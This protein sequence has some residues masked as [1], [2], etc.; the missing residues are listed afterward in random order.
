MCKIQTLFDVPSFFTSQERKL[1]EK[2]ESLK[3]KEELLQKKL[4]EINRKQTELEVLGYNK[5]VQDL[6]EICTDQ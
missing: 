4:Y 3:R 5:K 6:N 2:E 1:R